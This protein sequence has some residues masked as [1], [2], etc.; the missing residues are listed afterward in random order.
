MNTQCYHY[1]GN[2][3]SIGIITLQLITNYAIQ[4]IA[5]KKERNKA[6][7][8][9]EDYKA[10]CKAADEKLKDMKADKEAVKKSL[11]RKVSIV[12]YHIELYSTLWLTTFADHE[13]EKGHGYPKGNPR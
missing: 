12:S 10:R 5:A 3:I 1:Y 7:A 4:I 13:V 8:S 6:I 11:T 9:K 2:A